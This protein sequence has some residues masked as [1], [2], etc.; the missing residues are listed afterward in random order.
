MLRHDL[1]SAKLRLKNRFSLMKSNDYP[2]IAQ[3]G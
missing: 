2:Q 1:K 3:V